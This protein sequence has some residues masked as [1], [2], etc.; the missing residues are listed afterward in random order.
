MLPPV[1]LS[2]QLVRESYVRAEALRRT[3]AT[4]YRPLDREANRSPTAEHAESGSRL[5]SSSSSSRSSRD[6]A[7]ER[8]VTETRVE[9]IE[10][11]PTDGPRPS[12][13]PSP[14]LEAQARRAYS[15][16]APQD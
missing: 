1:G 8:V 12:R 3:G 5:R 9:V 10:A 15:R 11:V 14:F 2:P 13:P 4:G 6:R 16:F 7:G